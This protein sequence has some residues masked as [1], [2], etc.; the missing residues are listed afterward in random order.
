[1]FHEPGVENVY[2]LTERH[3]RVSPVLQ[4]PI[5]AVAIALNEEQSC[6]D[7]AANRLVYLNAVINSLKALKAQPAFST[8]S[9]SQLRPSASKPQKRGH[10]EVP[11]RPTVDLDELVKGPAFYRE[12][13]SFLLSE[14]DLIT[15]RFPRPDTSSNAPRG[16]AI[17]PI[18][19]DKKAA[20]D[21]CA[22]GF[23]TPFLT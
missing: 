14:E 1:M 23:F 11:Q 16:R 8:K 7:K 2:I 5:L 20:N 12:L 22:G 10:V 3:V 21:A 19:D 4:R 6:H 9:T 18:P 17:V 15:N 13:Q